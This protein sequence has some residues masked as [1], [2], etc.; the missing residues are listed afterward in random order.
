MKPLW[1]DDQHCQ[2]C[3]SGIVSCCRAVQRWEPLPF[4]GSVSCRKPATPL[5]CKPAL[6]H[7]LISSPS[8]LKRVPSPCSKS[9]T[10]CTKALKMTV[11]IHFCSQ[12]KC[13][14]RFE[15]TAHDQV[16]FVPAYVWAQRHSISD[17]LSY[18]RKPSTFAST[19]FLNA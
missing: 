4:S 5:F 12:K 7:V 14:C 9:L 16:N 2:H 17:R 18:L 15:L 6:Q 10:A 19:D 3:Q 8:S 11:F 1:I 13:S